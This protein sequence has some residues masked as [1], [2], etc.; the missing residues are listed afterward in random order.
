MSGTE[1]PVA[2]VTGGRHGIGRGIALELARAGFDLAITVRKSDQE[3][4]ATVAALAELGARARLFESD[5]ADLEAHEPLIQA[6]AHWAGGLDCLVNNAGISS[7]LRGDLLDLQ[8]SSFDDVLGVNLRG[9]FFLTQTAARWMV[10]HPSDHYRSI[11][12][13]SSVNA[14]MAA[15]ERGDYCLS[16]AGLSMAARLFALRLAEAEIG[17]FELRPGIIR[18]AMTEVAAERHEQRITEGQV[19]AGRW[20]TP[21]DIG[22]AAV[23]FATGAMAFATGSAIELDGGLSIRRL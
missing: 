13:V 14:V 22:V 18:T 4:D 8:V 20:G 9:G 17:V 3:A 23:P 5:L 21:E 10:A 11:L 12:F 19:P 7:H 2:L 6:V 1:R 15:T 16:K